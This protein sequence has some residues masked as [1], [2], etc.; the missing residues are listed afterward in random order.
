MSFDTLPYYCC[1]ESRDIDVCTQAP[2]PGP[3][4]NNLQRWYYDTGAGVCSLFNYGGCGGNGN[5]FATLQGCLIRCQE[6]ATCD[7]PPEVGSC[8][9][10]FQ[11]W[12]FN[13]KTSSCETFTFGGCSTNLNN[14]FSKG[15]CLARCGVDT[16]RSTCPGARQCDTTNL[17]ADNTCEFN[18]NATCTIDPCR[19]EVVFKDEFGKTVDCGKLL[20]KCLRD[21][22][23]HRL[24][25]YMPQCDENDAYKPLQCVD[26]G[27]ECWC[28]D[29]LGSEVPD[30]RV[31]GRT[32]SCRV[33]DVD[34][35]NIVL[36]FP[37]EFSTVEGQQQE[38]IELLIS[39]LMNDFQLTR[40]QIED[41]R[42]YRGSIIAEIVVTGENATNAVDFLQHN[43]REKHF[44]VELN[45]E[46]L[47]P[48]SAVATYYRSPISEKQLRELEHSNFVK[49]V[50]LA[51][52]G[53]VMGV[54]LIAGVIIC[55]VV[56]KKKNTKSADLDNPNAVVPTMYAAG[57]K[58]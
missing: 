3:C 49:K 14:F 50:V 33:N 5:N 2:N 25:N 57:P 17:C 45:G 39:V 11:R 27:S 52:V 15:E 51:V 4:D 18:P 12:F 54:L 55:C 28:V 35:V 36:R 8:R 9:S 38:F 21:R 48:D 13:S 44:V 53:S 29:S 46:L 34:K 37:V 1:A 58:Y 10:N 40:A 22:L 19:C 42:L 26:G 20:P 30:T 56:Q 23:A 7:T 47:V 41:I 24:G 31:S 32:P 43:V 16:T 6:R